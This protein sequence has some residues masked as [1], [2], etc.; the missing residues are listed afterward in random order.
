MPKPIFIVCSESGSADKYSNDVSIFNVLETLVFSSPATN[1]SG[2]VAR[3][4]DHVRITALWRADEDSSNGEYYHEFLIR[5]PGRE[6]IKVAGSA[7]LFRRNNHRFICDAFLPRG[8]CAPQETCDMLFISRIRSVGEEAWVSQEYPIAIKCTHH[9]Q[10][11][12]ERSLT[13]DSH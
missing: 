11:Q 5:I 13:T 8:D 10:G 6:D 7:F 1:E 4:I 2:R 12:T 9:S 3:D